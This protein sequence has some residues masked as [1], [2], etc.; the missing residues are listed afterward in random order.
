M[1]WKIDWAGIFEKLKTENIISYVLN[2]D[3][4]SMVTNPYVVVSTI[5]VICLLIFFKFVRTLAFLLGTVAI[6]LAL[7]YSF[8]EE[9]QEVVLGDIAVLGVTCF[10]AAACWIYIF[11]IRTD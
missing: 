2:L 8:P 1:D 4:I 6:G 9:G 11:L 7:I 3:I 10:L 5:L